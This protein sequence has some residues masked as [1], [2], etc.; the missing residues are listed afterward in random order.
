MSEEAYNNNDDYAVYDESSCRGHGKRTGLGFLSRS[1]KKGQ[2]AYNT[3]ILS[4]SKLIGNSDKNKESI[5]AKEF[6]KKNEEFYEEDSKTGVLGKKKEVIKT[7]D[8]G[9]LKKNRKNNKKNR[10]NV[11][12]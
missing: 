5:E 9:F 12:Y 7:K 8:H 1:I 4:K 6:L 3:H 11:N 10:K 2:T